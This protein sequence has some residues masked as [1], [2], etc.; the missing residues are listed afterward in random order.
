MLLINIDPEILY[1]ENA[2]TN[3]KRDKNGTKYIILE[4]DSL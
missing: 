4:N 3:H 2:T 1:K